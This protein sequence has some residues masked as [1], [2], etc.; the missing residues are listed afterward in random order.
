LFPGQGGHAARQSQYFRTLLRQ[1]ING[2]GPGDEQHRPGRLAGSD[3][4]ALRQFAPDQNLFYLRRLGDMAEEGIN[5]ALGAPMTTQQRGRNRIAIVS[6]L[7][8]GEVEIGLRRTITL[9]PK[10]MRALR[11]VPGVVEVEEI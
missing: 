8:T 11:A 3:T 2:V 6:D 1:K 5:D 9:S 10:F 4:H 7:G